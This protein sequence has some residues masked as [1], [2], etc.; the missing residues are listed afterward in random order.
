MAKNEPVVEKKPLET[1]KEKPADTPKEEVKQPIQETIQDNQ[2]RDRMVGKQDTSQK[3]ETLAAKT[4]KT[5]T[6]KVEPQPVVEDAVKEALPIQVGSLIE[7]ATARVNPTYPPAAKTMRMTGTVKVEVLVNEDGSIAEVQNTSG[8]SMLQ[9]A[10]TEALK[11]WK[12]KPFMR[13]GQPVKAT[14]FVSFNFNL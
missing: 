14:G 11:K 9:R 1:P 8:P 6:P 10:A 7:Y 3:V 5:E 13:D 4:T 12:F 2:S